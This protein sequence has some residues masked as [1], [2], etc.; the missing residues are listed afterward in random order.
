MRSK[1][2]NIKDQQYGDW[3]VVEFAGRQ[4]G[5]SMW[6]C[7]CKCGTEAFCSIGNLRSGRTT[8]CRI[9][10]TSGTP[11]THDGQTHSIKEWAKIVG[12]SCKL[13]YERLK[14]MPPEQAF[15]K[16][17]PSKENSMGKKIEFNG[18]TLTITQWAKKLG[19]SR[20]TLYRRLATLPPDQV[21]K[22]EN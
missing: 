5:N 6:L 15:K 18:V 19:I 8:K 2:L 13:L 16:I 7:R 4:K 9:C 3:T 14:T 1:P 17:L 20:V 11:I 12:I 22:H 10:S 21:L